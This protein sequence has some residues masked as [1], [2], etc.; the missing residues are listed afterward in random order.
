MR[1]NLELIES[2]YVVSK[3]DTYFDK[4]FKER[5]TGIY[6]YVHTECATYNEQLPEINKIVTLYIDADELEKALKEQAKSVCIS[7]IPYTTPDFTYICDD[8]KPNQILKY[9]RKIQRKEG[10]HFKDGKIR[11]GK[12]DNEFT[13]MCVDFANTMNTK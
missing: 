10:Y 4:I 13:Q 2:H 11:N 8:I 7:C 9:S 3:K 1:P 5:N 6:F 12:M